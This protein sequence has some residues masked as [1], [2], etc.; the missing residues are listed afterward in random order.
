MRLG[1]LRGFLIDLALAGVAT[2]F[3]FHPVWSFLHARPEVVYWGGGVLHIVL[4]PVLIVQ[5]MFGNLK[6]SE[7]IL[8]NRTSVHERAFVWSMIGAYG[9]SFIVP[10]ACTLLLP[11]E[12]SMG[13]SMAVLFAPVAG[14]LGPMLLVLMFPSVTQRDVKIPNP[15]ASRVGRVAM[16]LAITAYLVL[17][18]A[19]LFMAAESTQQVAGLMITLGFF[20]AYVPMRLFLFYA[21]ADDRREIVSLAASA[22]FVGVQLA[23]H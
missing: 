17:E 18:E 12:K 9:T 23:A 15:F 11:I 3:S 7:L 6:S 14:F 10:F 22:L 1:L 16:T 4:I 19:T 21:T 8:Q 20:L 2:A 13:F 5:T